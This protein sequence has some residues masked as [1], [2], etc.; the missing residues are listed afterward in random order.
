MELG[1]ARWMMM[2]TTISMVAMAISKPGRRREDHRRR[3]AEL[4]SEKRGRSPE[5]LKADGD[6]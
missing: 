1:A 6:R 3:S 5:E 4:G 2:T